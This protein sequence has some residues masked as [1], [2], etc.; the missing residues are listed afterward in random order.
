MLDFHRSHNF[1][2]INLTMYYSYFMTHNYELTFAFFPPVTK[3][4]KNSTRKQLYP[5]GTCTVPVRYK[6]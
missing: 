6:V 4:T 3:I 1:I 5:Q 2:H